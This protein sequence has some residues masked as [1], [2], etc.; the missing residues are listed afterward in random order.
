MVTDPIADLLVRLR[1][2]QQ[3]KKSNVVVPHSK[4]IWQIVSLLRE[5]GFVGEM[6]LRGKKVK[7]FIKIDLMGHVTG[8]ERI[9][10][11]GR[12]LW[13]SSKRWYPMHGGF[14]VFSTPQG[15]L[16]H[17]EARKRNVGGEVLFEIW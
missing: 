2:A 15:I 3:A 16:T 13:A 9:S 4:L 12:R 6:I 17:K 8:A 7:R 5:L 11:P 10:R 1:N 14:V